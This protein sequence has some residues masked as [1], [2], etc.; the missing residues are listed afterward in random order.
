MR[1]LDILGL[2]DEDLHRIDTILRQ[3][4]G[5]GLDDLHLR[6]RRRR[7]RRL[8]VLLLALLT[9]AAVL[10]SWRYGLWR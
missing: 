5:I 2:D 6:W 3:R 7:R 9:L 10:A 1:R 8:V 4:H